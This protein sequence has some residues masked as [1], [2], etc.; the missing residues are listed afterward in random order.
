MGFFSDLTGS[1]QKKALKRKAL[2]DLVASQTYGKRYDRAHNE[3]A[4]QQTLGQQAIIDS[5]GDA[6]DTQEQGYNQAL[7][8][9][10]PFIQDGGRATDLYFDALGINGDQAQNEFYQNEMNSPGFQEGLNTGVDALMSRYAATNT[11][12][13]GPDGLPRSGRVLKALQRHGNQYLNN[14]VGQK[15]GH[16]ASLQGQGYNA[17]QHAAGLTT[18]YFKNKGNLNLGYGQARNEYYTVPANTRYQGKLGKAQALFQ[19]QT[20]YNSGIAQSKIAKANATNNLFTQGLS[21]GTKL[22]DF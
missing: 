3:L 2:D 19:G 22:G 21:L 5:F 11:G 1:S 14:H 10:D 18:D 20:G 13:V 12:R 9:Y 4:D 8:Y 16:L 17:S 6:F 15:L 7:N